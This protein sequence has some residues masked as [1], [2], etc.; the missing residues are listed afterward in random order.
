MAGET[1]EP[2]KRAQQQGC[3]EQSG[4]I[5]TQRIGANQHTPAR[6]ACLLTSQGRWG[7]GAEAPDSEVRSQG[8]DWACLHEHSLKGAS[9]A[10]LARR[11]SRKKSRTA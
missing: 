10:Q 9:V 11:K 3:R 1:L 4:E 8:E 6:E 5:P 2:W 7:L